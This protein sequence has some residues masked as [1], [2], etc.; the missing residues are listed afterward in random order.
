MKCN[1][2]VAVIKDHSLK[3]CEHFSV[4]IDLSIFSVEYLQTCR[5]SRP[6][7]RKEKK[8]R[9]SSFSKRLGQISRRS[10]N[11][12]ISMNSF[13]EETSCGNRIASLRLPEVKKHFTPPRRIMSTSRSHCE[14]PANDVVEPLTFTEGMVALCRKG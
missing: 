6:L 3:E 5:L 7:G 13:E 1:C 12:T 11:P 14:P 2:I 4:R 10:V 9:S 8:F